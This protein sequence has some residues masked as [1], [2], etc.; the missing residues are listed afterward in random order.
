MIEILNEILKDL[1]EGKISD[2]GFE[3]ANIVLYT[4]DKKFFLNNEGKI[5]DIVDKIKKRIELRPDP[6]ICHEI[7]TAEKEIKEII[8]EEAQIDNII[9][10]PQRSI[11]IIEAEKPGLAIGKQGE[12]LREIRSK[13]LWVPIIKRTPPIRSQLIENIRS[14]LY[15][16]SDERRKFLNKVGERVYSGWLRA[17][18]EE[19]VRV[20]FLGG[21]RQVGRSSLLLQTPESRVLLDCGVDVASDE[22]AYPFL[23]VP[24]FNIKEL[25]AVIVSHSHLDHSG[26]VPYLFKFGYRGPVYCTAPTRD[27][28]SLLLLDYV[29][30]MRSEGKEPIYTSEEIKEMVKHTIT[31]DFEEVTDITPDVRITLY[32]A[33]HI[34]GSSMVH[35]HIGNGLHNLLYTGD[36]KFSKS[37]LLSPAYTIFPRLET[38]MIEATYGGR[39]NILPS[40]RE[41]NDYLKTIISDTIN[42]GGKVLMPVLG[43]GRAQD[44]MVLL[45]EFM[46]NKDIPNIKIYIDG[47]VW[48]VTAIHTAYPEF[49]NSSIRKQIFHKDNNPF[50]SESFNRIGSPRERKQVLEE[51]G[52]CVILAT[53]GMLV[54]GPSVEYLKALADNPKNSLVFTCYQGEGSLGRRI[55]RGEREITFKHGLKHEILPIKMEVYKV[56]LSDHSDRKELVNFVYRCQ[57]RPKKIIVTHGE[58]SRCLDLASTL[59]K[60]FKI[61]TQAPRNLESIR[62]K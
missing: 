31:L 43:S 58:N 6:S 61:E 53:S 42:K 62:I 13:T 44:I 33:G 12:N 29:K 21:A 50:L 5:R 20:S 1:P 45:E 30:I 41:V 25:D 56:E 28:M 16:N 11:V 19:W 49:L 39:D 40:K 32:N 4:K 23:E 22:H 15:N 55:Q 27:V 3:G 60:M 34:L 36:M 35:L 10:D 37:I 26:L 46:R 9:F 54:G 38:M 17:K 24:E 51:E 52:A 7:E 47:L 18:K 2:A 8:P 48:D 59:H 57:P 14:V